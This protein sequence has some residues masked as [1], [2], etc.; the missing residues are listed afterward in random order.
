VSTVFFIVGLVIT[1]IGVVF[2][3]L[4]R[5]EKPAPAAAESIDPGAILEQLNKMLELVEKQYRVGIIL[6]AVG[7]SLIGVGIWLEAKDAKDAAEDAA[8]ALMLVP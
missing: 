3:A 4:G 1:A 7:L 6:M 2:I 8:A 5:F